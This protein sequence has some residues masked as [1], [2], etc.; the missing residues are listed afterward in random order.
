MAVMRIKY[1]VH[2]WGNDFPAHGRE[3]FR[4]HNDLVRS[5]GEGRKFMEY[6]AKMGWAPLCDFL[7][8]PTVDQTHSFP[9]SD[10]WVEYKKMVQE[11]EKTQ[12]QT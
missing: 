4:K 6:D 1:N 12:S 7:G 10:D 2:C 9:R 11:Q 8:L 5:L 3:H